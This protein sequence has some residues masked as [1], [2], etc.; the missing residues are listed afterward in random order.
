VDFT[1]PA[2][3]FSQVDAGG[4]RVHFPGKYGVVVG[5]SSP[6]KRSADL[7]APDPARGT[8]TLV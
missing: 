7:G 2:S 8:L 6:G 5:P 3:A 4:K 1:L